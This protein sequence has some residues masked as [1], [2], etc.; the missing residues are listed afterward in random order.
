MHLL[1]SRTAAF[2]R[3]RGPRESHLTDMDPRSQAH[4]FRKSSQEQ[5][6]YESEPGFVRDANMDSC[7]PQGYNLLG[8]PLE[9]TIDGSRY[10][11]I[12]RC[13]FEGESNKDYTFYL[14]LD[15]IAQFLTQKE[16]AFQLNE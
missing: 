8:D 12:R 3:S 1:H 6:C 9:N 2:W 13:P 15:V 11:W 4:H 5:S 7:N 16:H 10:Y 14:A